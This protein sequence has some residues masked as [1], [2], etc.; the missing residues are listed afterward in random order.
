MKAS[1]GQKMTSNIKAADTSEREH[2]QRPS[3]LT[4][5]ASNRVF[6]GSKRRARRRLIIERLLLVAFGSVSPAYLFSS[7]PKE[8]RGPQPT[9]KGE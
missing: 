6:G 9:G 7:T 1:E 8:R 5:W 3:R 2:H 4:M